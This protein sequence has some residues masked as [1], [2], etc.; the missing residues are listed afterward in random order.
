MFDVVINPKIKHQNFKE[1]LHLNTASKV[2]F[3]RF[4]L[5]DLLYGFPCVHSTFIHGFPLI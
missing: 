2:K 3:S 5:I 1:R 4:C